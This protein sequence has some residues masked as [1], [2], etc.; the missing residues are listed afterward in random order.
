MKSRLFIGLLVVINLSLAGYVAARR[1]LFT[2]PQLIPVA[3]SHKMP[4]VEL[5][6]DTGRVFSTDQ[7]KGTA[8]FVQFINPYIEAQIT[9]FSKVRNNRPQKPISWMVLTANAQELRRRLPTD[10]NDVVIIE[11]NHE[12]LRYLLSISKS[13]EHWVIFDESGEYRN[14]GSYDT[15]D[16][17]NLLRNVVDD[18]PLYST[19]ILSEILTAMNE[20]GQLSRFHASAAN[21]V[22]GKA[23][24][25]MFSMACTSC[26][27]GSLVE[28]LNNHATQ[29]R[30]N[31]Y[32]I[33]LP[34]TFTKSDL[35]NFEINLEVSIPVHLANADFTRQ[36]SM[37]NE[38]YGE[39][40]IN[41]SVFVVD[42][43]KVLSV[44]SGMRETKRLLKELTE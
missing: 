42:K 19:E 38:R 32:V 16:A 43:E 26:P 27:D 4:R 25:A 21:S 3:Q 34:S 24:V 33:I 35:R 5:R 11:E 28:L 17:A 23:V 44:V 29:D 12:A 13:R 40:A 22:T 15:G 18:E 7:F 36:W 30:Q 14:S 9:S 8:L 39:K 41:G 31:S 6:D 1:Y 2:K 37:L 20:R 10:I